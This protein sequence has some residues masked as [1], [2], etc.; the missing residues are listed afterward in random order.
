MCY[1]IMS[2]DVIQ[3]M[4]MLVAVGLLFL[5]EE[6]TFWLLTMII[7]K[8]TPPDYYSPGLLGA[9]ADQVCCKY[10]SLYIG[11]IPASGLYCNPEGV[12]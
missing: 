5:D 10:R 4:N 12:N 3:G 6:T 11:I 7:E 8:M 2:Y 1:D 9:Q